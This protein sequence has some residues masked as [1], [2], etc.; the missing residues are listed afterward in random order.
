MGTIVVF[1]AISKMSMLVAV[2]ENDNII[3]RTVFNCE[4]LNVT[5]QNQ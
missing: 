2:V 1:I 3:K 5:N 4:I